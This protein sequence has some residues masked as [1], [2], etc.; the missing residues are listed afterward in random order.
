MYIF[1]DE[2]GTTDKKNKQGFLVLAF[3]LASNRAFVDELILSIKDQCKAKGKPIHSREV[4]YHDLTP[5]QREIAVKKINSKYRRFYVCFFDVDKADK[6]MVT[7]EYEQLIQMESIGHV[8]SKLNKIELK[9]EKF[10]KVIMDKKLQPAE[11]RRR[12][13]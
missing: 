8:L 11:R 9:K 1:I 2:S 12:R 10:I 4:K 5:F 6:Q 7:G 13:L 3:V